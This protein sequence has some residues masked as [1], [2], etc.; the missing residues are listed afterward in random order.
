MTTKLR[1]S[2]LPLLSAAVVF[3]VASYRPHT[4]ANVTTPE[5]APELERIYAPFESI[6]TDLND[7]RW[8][9]TD[10][11]LTTSVFGDFRSTHFHGGIDISTQGREGIPV[12]AMRA[13][14]VSLVRQSPHGYGNVVELTHADGFT[15][16][17]AHLKGFAPRL[18]ALVRPQLLRSGGVSADVRP[19]SGTLLVSAGELIGYSGSTGAGGPHHHFE[20]RDAQRNP[21]DPMLIP[22]FR[23]R[24]AD[25][26]AP[27]IEELG[28]V[29]LSA[30]TIVQGNV[31][32]VYVRPSR[33]TGVTTIDQRLRVTGDVGVTVRVRDAVGPRRF[34]NRNVALELLVDGV[35][36][37]AS[38]AARLPAD[39]SKQ[40]ALHYDWTAKSNGH[41]Y[42]QKLFIEE[43]N[44][45]PFYAR[46]PY[47]SGI[48]RSSDF[49]EGPHT[50][51]VLARDL[52]GNESRLRT[53][54]I[55]NHPP[56]VRAERTG[57]QIAVAP[58]NDIEVDRIVIG[59]SHDGIRIT[60]WRSIDASGLTRTDGRWVIEAP[61]QA[62]I[63]AVTALNRHGTASDP[64]WIAPALANVVPLHVSTEIMRDM[65]IVTVRSDL[66]LPTAPRVRVVAEADIPEP[67]VRS[68]SARQY[69]ASFPL[70]PD[71]G[72]SFTVEAVVEGGSGIAARGSD[73]VAV[74][75]ITPSMGGIAELPDRSFHLHFGPNGVLSDTY[76]QLERSYDGVR[77]EPS[78]RVLDRGATVEMDVPTELLGRKAG[79]F[80][81]NGGD[82]QLLTWRRAFGERRLTGHIHRFL[83]T[84]RVLEDETPPHFDR[85]YLSYRSETLLLELRIRDD[86]S[87]LS[88]SSIRVKVDGD[89][90]PATFD[91]DR[92]RLT[93]NERLR[94]LKGRHR[95]EVR[96]SDRM[97]NENVWVGTVS[98]R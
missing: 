30:G 86:R 93:V 66:P 45:L 71:V 69:V 40:I 8:P 7:Y 14:W 78:D 72:S 58:M 73:D 61:T 50:L 38:Q 51:E 36:V 39:D 41:P 62:T 21:I 85:A 98:V 26:I 65:A 91:S 63:I 56:A 43:G 23:G 25:K 6:A 94:L 35:S 9:M 88:T 87:G 12:M 90:V 76:V 54:V 22:S 44:R 59:T 34:T 2:A 49:T 11:F 24:V 57:R 79:L 28:F 18:D 67:A 20:I 19:D 68:L 97:E 96:A 64:A 70:R 52:N 27:T 29:P 75:P 53:N 4:P 82:D 77:A 74:A 46:A 31:R 92:R 5:G 89:P 60:P 55:F 15:T 48:L 47:G 17:Y 95:V 13:G 33:R 81:F 3:S 42:H 84:F 10:E 83:G 37:Y 1:R 32:P 80:V 16:W